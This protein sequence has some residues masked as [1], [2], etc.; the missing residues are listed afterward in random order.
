M[1]EILGILVLVVSLA[2]SVYTL[3]K[4]ERVIDE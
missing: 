1:Q 2:I 4:G 3:K